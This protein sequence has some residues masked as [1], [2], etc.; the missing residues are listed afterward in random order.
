M[1]TSLLPSQLGQLFRET[2][3][4]LDADSFLLENAHYGKVLS[5]K[6][7]RKTIKLFP[8]IK[9]VKKMAIYLY[10]FITQLHP[11]MPKLYT[12]LVFLSAIGLK[13]L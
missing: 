3:A 5:R 11:E 1:L 10:I 8:F 12:I 7:N 4:L 9:M 2:T 6:A 13:K